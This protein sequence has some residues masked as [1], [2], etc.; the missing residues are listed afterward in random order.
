MP[1]AGLEVLGVLRPQQLVLLDAC[2][3]AVD[4]DG[5]G[6]VAADPVVDLVRMQGL[7]H[8]ARSKKAT[9]R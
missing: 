5:E 1:L 6:V 2:V 8:R 3:E 9:S 7:A 4:E